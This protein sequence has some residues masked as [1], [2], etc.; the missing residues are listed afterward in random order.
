[1]YLGERN[2]RRKS[3]SSPVRVV[4]L[5]I[6]IGLSLYVYA[7]V[8]REEAESS[9]SLTPTP[10]RSALS[11]ATE[12]QELYMRGEL[13]PSMKIMRAALKVNAESE[14][15][16]FGA[17]LALE[18]AGNWKEA[19]ALLVHFLEKHPDNGPAHN[20]IG[21]TTVLHS[22]DLRTAERYIRRALML[23]PGHGYII[24]SLG[25]LLFKQGK[26]ASARR[27][28]RMA[29]R[30]SP[31]EAEVLAHLAEVNVS[32][33]NDTRAVEL[34]RLAISVSEDE[35]LTAKIKKRLEELVQGS[36]GKKNKERETRKA[37]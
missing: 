33:H 34:L 22:K 4:I 35:H 13:E 32:L 15:L 2:R 24:D 18:R 17:A 16:Y 12:A 37:Q 19:N 29:I 8:R 6:L 30:L 23:D 26:L 5:L 7:L 11:Y 20:F 27:L 14:D 25:W 10:T 21:Y 1:M 9:T 3:R 28:L 36:A 31:R